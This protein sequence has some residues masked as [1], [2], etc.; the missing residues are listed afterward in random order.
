[1]SRWQYMLMTVPHDIPAQNDILT[2]SS[3]HKNVSFLAG[4]IH[5]S[6]LIACKGI[7]IHL[8]KHSIFVLS[9]ARLKKK[10]LHILYDK[11]AKQ[12]P[13]IAA[14]RALMGSI[15]VTMTL[16]PKPRRAWTHPL[17]T[18][19]YPATTATFPAIITSVARL[20]PSIRDSRQPY[21]LSNL[22]CAKKVN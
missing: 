16:A 8:I 6:H 13:S 11:W 18:S 20:I 15:S 9:L 12:V 7:Q 1:M 2:A 3:C 10:K 5:C 22:L 17:P 14:C 21:R 4:L 19:P